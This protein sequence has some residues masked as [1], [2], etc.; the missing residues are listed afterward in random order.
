MSLTTARPEA[1][2]DPPPTRRARRARW[3]LPVVPLVIAVV[4]FLGVGVLL[5]P[6]AAAWMSQYQQSLRI[7]DYAHE[8]EIAGPDALATELARASDYNAALTGGGVPRPRRAHPA[9]R[10]GRCGVR[11]SAR[12]R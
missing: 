3:R 7:D 12:R 2:A 5:Y 1:P 10:R 11:R 8:V 4:C 6:A 9:V